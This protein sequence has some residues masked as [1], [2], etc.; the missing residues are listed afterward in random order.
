MNIT[1]GQTVY[2]MVR[3][4]N[5]NSNL[6]V[7]PA[8]FTSTVYKNGAIDTGTTVTMSLSDAA[9]GMY[10]ASWSASTFGTYQLH[11]ENNTTDVVYVS[12]IYISTLGGAGG[13]ATVY[14]GF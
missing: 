11:I 7:V 8:T 6:P 1:T 3:S 13:S 9:E 10:T 12:E 14:V 5:P 4:F 2:E